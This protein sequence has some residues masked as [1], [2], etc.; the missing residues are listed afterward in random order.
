V[1]GIKTPLLCEWRLV[2]LDKFE[3]YRLKVSAKP[4]CQP[5][6]FSVVSNL[7]IKRLTRATPTGQSA[8]AA[9]KEVSP[10]S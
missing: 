5:E 7:P 3:K 2:R 1:Q 8:L 9:S 6:R 10:H 4:T